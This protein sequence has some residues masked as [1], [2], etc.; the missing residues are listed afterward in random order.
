M[1][2]FV[3]LL[4]LAVMIKHVFKIF[5]HFLNESFRMANTIYHGSPWIVIAVTISNLK[6]HY[7]KMWVESEL[8][9]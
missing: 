9:L 2:P 7:K 5:E 3:T 8:Y 4:S 1:T 6:A